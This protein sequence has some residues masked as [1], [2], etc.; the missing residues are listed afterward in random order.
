MRCRHFSSCAKNI[1]YTVN[2]ARR[3]PYLCQADGFLQVR[4]L[5]LATWR[6]PALLIQFRH[7]GRRPSTTAASPSRQ[8]LQAHNCLFELFAFLT[9][10]RKDLCY[11]HFAPEKNLAG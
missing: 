7:P 10:F 4:S 6:T 1:C 11:V 5:V 8:T 2:E 9:Q 3:S